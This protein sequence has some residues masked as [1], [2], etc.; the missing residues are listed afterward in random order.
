MVFHFLMEDCSHSLHVLLEA[1]AQIV[2]AVVESLGEFIH[3][4]LIAERGVLVVEGCIKLLHLDFV[5]LPVWIWFLSH[6]LDRLEVPL[7]LP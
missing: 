1:C 5:L 3:F 4:I 6:C 7:R 2:D